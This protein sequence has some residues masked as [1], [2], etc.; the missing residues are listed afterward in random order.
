MRVSL[1]LLVK[2]GDSYGSGVIWAIESTGI[3]V[4]YS[5]TLIRDKFVLFPKE[6]DE[7]PIGS[8]SLQQARRKS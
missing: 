2:V 8:L 5:A 1:S 4:R 3:W 6:V 7:A